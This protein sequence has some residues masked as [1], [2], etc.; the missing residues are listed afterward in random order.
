M[1]QPVDE[2]VAVAVG[3]AAAGEAAAAGPEGAAWC[4]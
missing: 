4:M 2:A 1:L 3:A